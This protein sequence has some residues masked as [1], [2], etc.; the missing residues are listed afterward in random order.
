[1]LNFAAWPIGMRVIAGKGRP[2]PGAQMRFTDIG[3]HRFT[4]SCDQH[5]R[6]PA[7]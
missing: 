3:G 1:M 7:R 6:R 2:H 4:L 5:P